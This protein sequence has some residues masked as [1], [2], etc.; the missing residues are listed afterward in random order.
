MIREVL[1]PQCP[2]LF[3]DV[4]FDG[5]PVL[6]E[7]FQVT[8]DPQK[9]V[10]PNADCLIV[11]QRST[12][13]RPLYALSAG[14]GARSKAKIPPRPQGLV[15]LEACGGP[16]ECS[17]RPEWGLEVLAYSQ[18]E[19]GLIYLSGEKMRGTSAWNPSVDL[20][21]P[22]AWSLLTLAVPP[23]TVGAIVSVSSLVEC[24]MQIDLYDAVVLGPEVHRSQGITLDRPRMIKDIILNALH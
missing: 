3:S 10:S 18:L 9:P 2:Q 4:P 21:P 12:G 19:D 17:K 7:R 15:A 20:L 8:K 23:A 14:L 22:S 5:I 6:V 16:T 1:Q 11:H 13:A 24:V